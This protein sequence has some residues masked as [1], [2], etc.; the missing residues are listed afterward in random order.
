MVPL[1]SVAAATAVCAAFAGSGVPLTDGSAHLGRRA[2]DAVAA[3][4]LAPAV[5]TVY[6]EIA[7]QNAMPEAATIADQLIRH[8]RR[9][10][11]NRNALYYLDPS[12]APRWPAQLRVVVC[13]GTSDPGVAGRDM[14]FRARVGGQDI[15]TL[16]VGRPARHTRLSRRLRGPGVGHLP[17]PGYFDGEVGN[18]HIHDL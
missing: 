1:A 4:T 5:K 16:A 14:D 17:S 7:T 12:F 9:V 18:R 3:A 13:C 2:W 10:E 8:H 6:V 11:V 15:Y